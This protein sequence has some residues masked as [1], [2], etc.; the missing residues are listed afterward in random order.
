MVGR[1]DSLEHVMFASC[2]EGLIP[3]EPGSGLMLAFDEKDLHYHLQNISP[4]LAPLPLQLSSLCS[5]VALTIIF[6]NKKMM[7]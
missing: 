3:L 4:V 5:S 6:V 2:L 7:K 1:L